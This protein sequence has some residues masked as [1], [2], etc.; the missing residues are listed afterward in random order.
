[1]TNELERCLSEWATFDTR[2]LISALMQKAEDIRTRQLVKTLKKLPPLSEEE[3]SN[4]EA[5]TKSIVT[6]I[7]QDPIQYLKKNKN[8]G[9]SPGLVNDLFRLDLQKNDD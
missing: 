6:K 5:M 3:Q 1:M 2:P 4:L 9:E 8:N 7:L